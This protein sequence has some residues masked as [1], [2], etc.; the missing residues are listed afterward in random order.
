MGLPIAG[1]IFGCT[2]ETMEEV[3]GRRLFGLPGSQWHTVQHVK[4]GMPLFLYNFS[5]KVQMA[6]PL[7]QYTRGTKGAHLADNNHS[8]KSCSQVQDLWPPI[9]DADLHAAATWRL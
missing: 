5:E 7:L 9:A 1:H 2:D 3:L 6:L 8:C 4:A